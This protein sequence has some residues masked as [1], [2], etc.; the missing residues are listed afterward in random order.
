VQNRNDKCVSVQSYLRRVQD[1]APFLKN[2]SATY[3]SCLYQQPHNRKC[4]ILSIS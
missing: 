3:I 1:R 2:T 4:F